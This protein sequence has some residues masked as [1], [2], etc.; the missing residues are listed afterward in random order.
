MLRASS[1]VTPIFGIAV[2]GSI[3]GGFR[4]QSIMFDGVFGSS[5]AK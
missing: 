2:R 3:F 5:P 1:S 4:N